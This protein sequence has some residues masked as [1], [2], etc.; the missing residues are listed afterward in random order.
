SASRDPN[1]PPSTAPSLA[2]AADSP[3]NSRLAAS[4]SSPSTHRY[5]VGGMSIP[6]TSMSSLESG[7]AFAASPRFTYA[8]PGVASRNE[9]NA[10]MTDIARTSVQLLNAVGHRRRNGRP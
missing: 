9:E 7:L 10:R 2:A 6:S 5:A 8:N 4:R 1:A 3:S